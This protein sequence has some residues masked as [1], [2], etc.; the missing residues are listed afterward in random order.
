M[1]LT[2]PRITLPAHRRGREPPW[3]MDTEVSNSKSD[4]KKHQRSHVMVLF[5]T[6]HTVT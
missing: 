1:L 3:Q 6:P 5:D 2:T 4:L